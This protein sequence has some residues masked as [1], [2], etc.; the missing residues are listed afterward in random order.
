MTSADIITL[1]TIYCAHVQRAEATIS[2]R[3]AGQARL[4][5]T[6][7]TGGG[8]T[9]RTYQRV[10][11]WFDANWPADLAWPAHTS[12]VRSPPPP[13]HPHSFATHSHSI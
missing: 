8:C 5:A 4:F 11:S 7:R 3:A 10:M 13:P 9:L 1:A 6:L 2:A 12:T